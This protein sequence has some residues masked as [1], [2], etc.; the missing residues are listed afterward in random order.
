M[1]DAAPPVGLV[2]I[3]CDTRGAHEARIALDCLKVSRFELTL[4]LQTQNQQAANLSPTPLFT[5][6]STSRPKSL[7]LQ[8]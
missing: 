7:G 5:R 8:T 1:A 4:C 2:E 3:G 6:L